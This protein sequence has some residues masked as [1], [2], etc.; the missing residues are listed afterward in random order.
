MRAVIDTS[1]VMSAA[2]SP[3][4][5]P[6]T[7]MRRWRQRQFTPIV[8]PALLN[9]YRRALSYPHVRA[10]HGASDA[11]L[12]GLIR[13]FRAV[14]TVVVPSRTLSIIEVDLSDNRVIECAVAGDAP[15]IVS[16]DRPLRDLGTYK[17]K[18]VISP[19]AF[20]LLLD[21]NGIFG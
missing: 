2:I 10:R 18:R 1:I 7:V 20:D 19:G 6:A 13:E 12:D 4:G 3:P 11:E 8:S 9:E 14:A 15:F 17:G 16:G 5:V 21:A